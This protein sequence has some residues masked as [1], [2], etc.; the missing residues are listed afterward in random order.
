MTGEVEVGRYV[1][2]EGP[3]HKAGGPSEAQCGGG[4]VVSYLAFFPKSG[5]LLLE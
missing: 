2:P 1:G 4:R 3:T 5:S